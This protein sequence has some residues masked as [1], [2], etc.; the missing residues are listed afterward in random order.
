MSF[1][2]W[3]FI[4]LFTG[5]IGM[6]YFV[7]GKKQSKPVPLVAGLALMIYPY[8]IDSLAW[9]L[10]IGAVLIAIPFIYRPE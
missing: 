8:F 2:T 6:A 9:T 7:Y 3:L 5:V 1:E 4:G 10:A